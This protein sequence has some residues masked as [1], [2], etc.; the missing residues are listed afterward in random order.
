[1][2]WGTIVLV[3]VLLFLSFFIFVRTSIL[4]FVFEG[5]EGA[6]VL[7]HVFNKEGTECD[8]SRSFHRCI[9]IA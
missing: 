6:K 3:V 9:K 5:W 8:D 7:T 4:P 1:M 2:I